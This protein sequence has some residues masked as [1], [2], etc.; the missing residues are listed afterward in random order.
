MG[1]LQTESRSLLQLNVQN[2]NTWLS[3]LQDQSLI[4]Y[5]FKEAGPVE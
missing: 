4:S 3:G 2:L 1:H 5:Y